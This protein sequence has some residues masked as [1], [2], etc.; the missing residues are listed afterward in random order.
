MVN[1]IW[2]SKKKKKGCD[3]TPK[4]VKKAIEQMDEE[5]FMVVVKQLDIPDK[6]K[7]KMEDA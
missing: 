5:D 6:L 3:G 7:G 1:I 4:Q 2:P